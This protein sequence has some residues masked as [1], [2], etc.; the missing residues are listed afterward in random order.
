MITAVS[1]LRPPYGGFISE[2]ATTAIHTW[3]PDPEALKKIVGTS[4]KL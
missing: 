2:T 1:L 4:R 3:I